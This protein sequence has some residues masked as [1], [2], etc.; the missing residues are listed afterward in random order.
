MRIRIEECLLFSLTV[1]VD[2]KRTQVAQQRLGGELV[3]DKDLVT[4]GR[5]DFAAN[6]QFIAILETGVFQ[7]SFK[8]RI[9]RDG[10]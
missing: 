9:R 5:G 1:D 10:E 4:S 2:E 6:D 3:V 8:L 7:E